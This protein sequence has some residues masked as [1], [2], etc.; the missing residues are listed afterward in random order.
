MKLLLLTQYFPPE[1]GA[2]QNRLYELAVRLQ[3]RG[4]EVTVLTAMPNYPQME[5]HAAYKGKSYHYEEM[6]GLKVHRSSIYVTKEKGIAKRLRNYFSFVWSSWRCGKSKLEKHYDYI[7]CESPPLFLGISAWMLCRSKKAKLIFNVSDLWPESAEKLGLVTNKF[8]LGAARKLEEGLYKRS[9]LI[10]GQTQGIVADIQRRFPHKTVYWLPNGVDLN[11]YRHDAQPQGWREKNNFAAD[12]FLLLYAG[13]IG[14]AQGLEVILKAAHRL[15]EHKGIHFLLLGSG[16]VK[17]ELLAM[18]AELQLNNV[19]F[20]DTVPKAEMPAIV[21]AADAAVIPL[22]R[23]D[24]FKGAIPS[25]IFENLAMKKPIVLGVEGEAK[26]LF[27]DQGKAG[28]FFTPENEEELADAVLKLYHNPALRQELAENAYHYV[29]EKFNRDTIA[30][31]LYQLLVKH[32][33]KAQ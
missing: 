26:E 23:L 7:L 28:V 12:D 10:T 13:I 11:Y 29:R 8:F 15:R 33:A 9:T 5:I 14:H 3:Q 20:I 1:V 6:D 31:G 2:P 4:I 16:P 22:R 21:A 27:I 18:K 32:S 19:V 25:K 17:D 24:L 30:E